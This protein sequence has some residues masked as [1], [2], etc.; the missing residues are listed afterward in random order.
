M[1]F[2]NQAAQ[3]IFDHPLPL[4]RKRTDQMRLLVWTTCEEAL[5]EYVTVVL[6]GS[7][8]TQPGTD[9]PIKVFLDFCA[10]GFDAGEMLSEK[11]PG[12]YPLIENDETIELTQVGLNEIL[13]S[14][15]DAMFVQGGLQK[16]LPIEQIAQSA[17]FEV[18]R[19]TRVSEDLLFYAENTHLAWDS[20]EKPLKETLEDLHADPYNWR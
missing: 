7:Q 13:Q 18:K 17:V 20:G 8:A 5:L 1:S 19:R 9:E 4:L 12:L 11:A 6:S 2:F 15:Y 14:D 3:D 10:E 16:I